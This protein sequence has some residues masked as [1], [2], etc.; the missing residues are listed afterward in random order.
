M[1][2]VNI[3][4]IAALSFTLCGA[5]T[6]AVAQDK[7]AN[8][9][10]TQTT[11]NFII[12]EG[13]TREDIQKVFQEYFDKV[14]SKSTLIKH[15]AVYIHAWG[16]HGASYVQSMELSSWEDIGKLNNEIE[17][18]EKAAWPEESTRNAF[19]KK[20]ASYSDAHHSDEIYSVLNSMRK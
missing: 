15:Y 19:L 4:P 18:L 5:G 10:I 6:Q 1:K 17:A 12:P 9:Y 13:S 11:T 2:L 20:L 16:S 3:L 8:T 14:I 7:P